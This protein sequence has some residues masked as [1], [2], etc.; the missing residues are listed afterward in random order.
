MAECRNTA[1]RL[2]EKGEIPYDCRCADGCDRRVTRRKLNWRRQEGI[3]KG[4]CLKGGCMYRDAAS[5]ACIGCGF[6]AG[7]YLRRKEL[8]LEVLPNG[9]RGMNVGVMKN[10][11]A[12]SIATDEED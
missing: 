2:R 3:Q 5:A 8:P 12:D 1:C 4:N 9:L 10:P 11:C 7:E 6:D